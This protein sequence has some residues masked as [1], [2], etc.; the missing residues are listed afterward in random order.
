MSPSEEA[1]RGR[2]SAAERLRLG[3]ALLDEGCAALARL[4]LVR[5]ASRRTHRRI[6]RAAAVVSLALGL[7]GAAPLATPAAAVTSAPN[8]AATSTNPFGLTQ[9]LGTTLTSPEL[10]DIDGDGDL[11]TF[12]GKVN[13]DIVFFRNTGSAIAPAFAA[14][15]TNAFGLGGVGS[16]GHPALADIDGDGDLDAFVGAGSGNTAFFTQHRQRHGAGLCR[17]LRQRLRADLGR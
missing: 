15:S 9:L 10:A 4:R 14:A 11:D 3:A 6:A 5:G 1:R 7:L 17:F 8:F 2:L 12:I 13:G 16:Y